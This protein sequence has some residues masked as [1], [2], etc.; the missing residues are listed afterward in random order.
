MIITAKM[1]SKNQVM[2]PKAVRLRN[3]LNLKNTGFCHCLQRLIA[4]EF[5]E[6]HFY[7]TFG[8]SIRMRGLVGTW[9]LI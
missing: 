7:S 2:I 3:T 1:T 5:T 4:M 8:Q 9:L 6:Q